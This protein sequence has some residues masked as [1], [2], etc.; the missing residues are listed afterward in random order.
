LEKTGFYHSA[1]NDI[2]GIFGSRGSFFDST[3]QEGGK[4]PKNA[5][6]SKQSHPA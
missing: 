5:M 3:F 6:I 2:D 4:L 1:F